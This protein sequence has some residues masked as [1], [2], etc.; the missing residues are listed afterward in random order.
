MDKCKD[1]HIDLS[2]TSYRDQITLKCIT[3]G[4]FSIYFAIC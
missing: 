2:Q 3:L 4:V 1:V